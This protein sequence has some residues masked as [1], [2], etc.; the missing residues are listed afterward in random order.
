MGER[1]GAY[2]LAAIKVGLNVSEPSSTPPAW[3]IWWVTHVLSNTDLQWRINWFDYL[4][5]V[6]LTRNSSKELWDLLRML[7][8][9]NTGPSSPCTVN[10]A[11]PKVSFAQPFHIIQ[12]LKTGIWWLQ[13]FHAK[14]DDRHHGH[15]KHQRIFI[16]QLM[17][18]LRNTYYC[19]P[20]C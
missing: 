19:T 8:K 18:H 10:Q 11:I 20:F 3:I 15:V 7:T 13:I 4:T 9:S 1:R 5:N 2:F 14:T 6:H 16:F 17:P 12:Y